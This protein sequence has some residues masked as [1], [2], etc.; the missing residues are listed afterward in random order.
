MILLAHEYYISPFIIY[1]IH[2]GNGIKL[3]LILLASIFAFLTIL[4][5]ILL[6]KTTDDGKD[7]EKNQY[8]KSQI[9]SAILTFVFIIIFAVFPNEESLYKIAISSVINNDNFHEVEASPIEFIDF[10]Y[11]EIKDKEH[12]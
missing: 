11:N 7:I 5:H 8:F 9:V 2:N 6:N 1:L 10:I 3:A 12:P 4:F